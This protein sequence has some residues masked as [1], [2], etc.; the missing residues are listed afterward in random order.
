MAPT[1]SD[2][3]QH[4]HA[5]TSD[6]QQAPPILYPPSIEKDDSTSVVRANTSN[7]DNLSTPSCETTVAQQ[8][9]IIKGR[10]N[11]QPAICQRIFMLSAPDET[12]IAHQIRALREYVE[13]KEEVTDEWMSSL[14]FTLNECR[15]THLYRTSVIADSVSKVKS[16]LSSRLKIHKASTAPVIG[17]VFTG[18]GAQWPGMGKDLLET[19]PVFRQSMERANYYMMRLGAPYDVIDEILKPNDISR[20]SD[21]LLSQP[22]CSALQIALVDL[23]ASW[24]IYPN[25][26]TGHSSGEIAAA[27]AAGMLSMQDG[28]TVAYFRGVCARNLVE[29]Q[30]R[31]AMMAVGMSASDAE[32]YVD[33]L[34]EGKVTVACVNSPSSITISG[35]E[36]A[37][38]EL[39]TVLRGK[40]FFVQRL[41]IE[42]AYHSHHM[43]LIS[44]EY[45]GSI[46]HISPLTSPIHPAHH[47]ERSVQYFSSVYGRE[48]SAAGL[49]PDYWVENL[50]GQVKFV[51]ALRALCYETGHFERGIH[52]TNPV[53]Q[54]ATVDTLIEIG[55]HAALAGPIRQIIKADKNL[56]SANPAYSSIL[57]KSMDT[58]SSS[59]AVAASLA[60]TGYP[61]NFQAINSPAPMSTR[62]VLLDLPP[63]LRSEELPY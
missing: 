31:G 19:Y 29:K 8:Q 20:L 14:A 34:Q 53:T 54:Q 58:V 59:L 55:P 40:R 13:E 56:E 22:I 52:T 42:A 51:G 62:Q 57:I 49:G 18:Q 26:V 21:P 3:P 7:I 27:Y 33:A 37:I 9:P 35:D 43:D 28:I 60:C 17:F 46:A 38:A 6:L 1:S 41:D 47:H 16:R 39:E 30:R 23:L 61:V 25:G 11:H 44:G 50:A 32:P 15:P 5:L 45:L 4:A 24:G 63:D 10:A 12:S 48:I 36:A 2:L